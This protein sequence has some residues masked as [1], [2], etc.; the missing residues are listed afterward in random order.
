MAYKFQLGNAIMD[1]ALE[2]EG[3]ITI[4]GGKLTASA[5]FEGASLTIQNVAIVSNAKAL[6]NVTTI[7]GASSIQGNNLSLGG[8][9]ATIS[10]AVD[11][12]WETI[13][14]F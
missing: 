2:Q 4:D 13:A 12:D 10:A 8:G 14:T 7:S 6:G 1:G 9:N 3:N 5:G 11:R